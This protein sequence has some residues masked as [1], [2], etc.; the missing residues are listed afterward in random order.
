MD[1]PEVSF[2]AVPAGPDGEPLL[3]AND[4][5]SFNRYV[6]WLADY[7]YRPHRLASPSPS[8]TVEQAWARVSAI[9]AEIACWLW[10]HPFEDYPPDA[11]AS[12]PRHMDYPHRVEL[13]HALSRVPLKQ[14][15]EELL[16][17]FY[18]ELFTDAHK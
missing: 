3:V 16:R 2:R 15:R 9:E 8:L 11:T 17:R 12:M 18:R 5:W 4:E 10:E 7:L 1:H 6:D 13:S 14:D